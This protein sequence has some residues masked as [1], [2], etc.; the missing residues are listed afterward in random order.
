[1]LFPEL[2]ICQSKVPENKPPPGSHGDPYEESRP[3]PETSFTCFSNSSIKVLIKKNFTLPLKALG[4]E[5]PHVPQNGA[6][7]ETN[8]HFQIVTLEY[9]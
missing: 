3:F 9:P 5:H 8:A 7:M 2:S 1:M 6:P 4:K